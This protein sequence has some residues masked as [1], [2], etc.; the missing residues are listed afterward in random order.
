MG[1]LIDNIQNPS[2]IIQI[3]SK[4]RPDYAKGCSPFLTDLNLIYSNC[5]TSRFHTEIM[6]KMHIW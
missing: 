5:V 2:H 4:L 6:Q 1:I 3:N